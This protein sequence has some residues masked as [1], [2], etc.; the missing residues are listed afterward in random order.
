MGTLG[1]EEENMKHI[2]LGLVL[3]FCIGLVACQPGGGGGITGGTVTVPDKSAT[4]TIPADT[5]STPVAIS[6]ERETIPVPDPLEYT[7]LG[8]GFRLNAPSEFSA[9]KDAILD[10]QGSALTVAGKPLTPQNVPADAVLVALVKRPTDS[11]YRML[12]MIP[13]SEIQTQAPTASWRIYLD[14]YY[15]CRF[16]TI[17][18]V[19]LRPNRIEINAPNPL[20]EGAAAKATITA[21]NKLDEPALISYIVVNWSSSDPSVASIDSTGLLKGEKIGTTTISAQA[22][23]FNAQKVVNVVAS[24]PVLFAANYNA[25]TIKGYSKG[26][27]ASSGTPAPLVTIT[28]PAGTKP[29]DLA[30]DPSG[31]LWV[32][33]NADNA[34]RLLRLTPAQLQSTGSP[35]PDVII[36][37]AYVNSIAGLSLEKPVAMTFDSSGNL[38]VSSTT[39]RVVRFAASSLAATGSPQPDRAITQNMNFPSGVAVDGSSNLWVA[40]YSGNTIARFTPSEQQNNTAP[41]Y[42]LN[43]GLTNPVGLEFDTG[44]NLYVGKTSGVGVFTSSQLSAAPTAPSR[45]IGAGTIVLGYRCQQRHALGK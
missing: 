10:I 13:S 6:I 20:A 25:G 1:F 12:P 5:F 29:N 39:N 24:A 38:W 40:N 16:C 34:N 19:V 26:Q 21:F 32:S 22:S 28:L 44:G 31:N 23:S 4:L 37:A 45:T 11:S 8:Q 17:I 41:S 33:D 7:G 36:S 30:F 43:A 3:A 35:T 2:K 14:S 27:A 15:I 9:T 18:A 42:V